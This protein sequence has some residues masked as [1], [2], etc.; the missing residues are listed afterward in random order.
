MASTILGIAHFT[1]L[2]GK[3][4]DFRCL[5]DRCRQIVDTQDTGTLRYDIYVTEDQTQAVVIEEYENEGALRAH[6]EHIGEELSA[7]VL[8]TANVHGQL[9]GDLSE[10]LRKSLVGGPVMAFG[11]LDA[12]R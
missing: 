2:D 10:E 3:F 1:F 11:S 5:S 9:L 6:G 12:Y 7:A 4:D 8:A